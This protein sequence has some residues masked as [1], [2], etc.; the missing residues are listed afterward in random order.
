MS[1]LGEVASFLLSGRVVR[2]VGTVIE[3]IGPPAPSEGLSHPH[4]GWQ[5]GSMPRSS[6]SRTSG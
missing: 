4:G 1:R 6:A 2:V 5:G 3:S